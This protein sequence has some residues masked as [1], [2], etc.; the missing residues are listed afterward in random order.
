[1][2]ARTLKPLDSLTV[3]LIFCIFRLSN[4]LKFIFCFGDN[5]DQVKFFYLLL[6]LIFVFVEEEDSL[7]EEQQ[8]L[9]LSSTCV[10]FDDLCEGESQV[11]ASALVSARERPR[12]MIK[13]NLTANPNWKRN[14]YKTNTEAN[15]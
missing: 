15:G 4:S 1:M 10:D 9:Q 6:Y 7:T 3:S 14:I 2:K 5:L 8:Q 13:A 11:R 12:A